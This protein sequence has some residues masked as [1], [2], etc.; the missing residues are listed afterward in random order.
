MADVDKLST[1]SVI[2]QA[3][4][5]HYRAIALIVLLA[6]LGQIATFQGEGYAQAAVHVSR[7]NSQVVGIAQKLVIWAE[8]LGNPVANPLT[9]RQYYARRVESGLKGLTPLTDKLDSETR[10]LSSNPRITES[11]LQEEAI[12]SDVRLDLE[13]GLARFESGSVQQGRAEIVPQEH[14]QML[15]RAGENLATLLN[16]LQVAIE[17][18]HQEIATIALMTIVVALGLVA[19]MHIRPMQKRLEETVSAE[20]ERIQLRAE[21]AASRRQAEMLTEALSRAEEASRQKTE[22]LSNVSHEIRTPMNGLIGMAELLSWTRLD[23]DQRDQL[24]AISSS[25]ETLMQLLNELLDLSKIE[26]GK[27][28]ISFEDV[29]LETLLRDVLKLHR[30]EARRKGIELTGKVVG[31]GPESIRADPIRLRQI[32]I[33]LIGN[34]LK[35]TF[36][37]SVSVCLESKS[38]PD[39]SST[40]LIAVADTGIGIDTGALSR[41]FE[42]FVQAEDSTSRRFGGTGLGL[43]IVRQLTHLM[44]GRI[45]AESVQGSGSSFYVELPTAAAT[46]PKAEVDIADDSGPVEALKG[47]RV[48]LAEDNL[49]SQRVGAGLLRRLGCEA[50]IA[51]DGSTALEMVR[52]HDFDAVLLDLRMPMMDGYEVASSIREIDGQ[53]RTHTILVALTADAMEGTEEKCLAAGMDAFLSKPVRPPA[54]RQTLLKLLAERRAA[55]S[56]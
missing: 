24:H 35:F 52:A 33:N 44:G 31:D 38:A 2:R 49:V 43:A 16:E 11:L 50:A 14:L 6:I 45:W 9:R 56:V 32:L 26:A 1:V 21:Q 4:I 40:L 22:F 51:G 19:G 3:G 46:K 34:A 25:A 53:R 12:I 15:E 36:E 47:M 10:A 7:L 55:A 39:G 13:A 20:G 18:R 28:R 29:S 30:I 48:L 37:G 5:R 8:V 17:Y 41:V 54:L 42:P 23:E 27:L